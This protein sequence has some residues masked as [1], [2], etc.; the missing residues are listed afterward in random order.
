MCVKRGGVCL[1]QAEQLQQQRVL[2]QQT[3]P[4][5]G[6]ARAWRRRRQLLPARGAA[7]V[8]PAVRR[9][10]V[11]VDPGDH[12]RRR[13]RLH[14]ARLHVAQGAAGAAAAAA[15]R[16]VDR[17]HGHHHR[18]RLHAGRPEPAVGHRALPQQRT[19]KVHPRPPR[20]RHPQDAPSQGEYLVFARETFQLSL[21]QFFN[22]TEGLTFLT[23]PA[24]FSPKCFAVI[25]VC[26]FYQD[27]C[28]HR[29][30]S[31]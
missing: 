26:F 9:A 19:H 22:P 4:A 29:L 5:G 11:G 28:S 21:L 10:V 31:K 8:R 23:E 2:A 14:L 6:A 20:Q 13:L 25:F 3:V 12:A 7:R 15:A 27:M 16:A 30:Y 17:L 1:L 18:G 24:L